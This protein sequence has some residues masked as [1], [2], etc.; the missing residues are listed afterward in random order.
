MEQNRDNIDSENTPQAPNDQTQRTGR[1]PLVRPLAQTHATFIKQLC[2]CR[3]N[4]L[5]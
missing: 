2:R 3:I 4:V 5:Q 1:N